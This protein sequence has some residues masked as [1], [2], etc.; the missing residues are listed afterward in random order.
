[1][2]TKYN[3]R[4][5]GIKIPHLKIL[6]RNENIHEIFTS[7]PIIAYSKDKSIG[8]VII[9]SRLPQDYTAKVDP[10]RGRP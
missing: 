5:K 1:M 10:G 8:D 9:R 2:V 7:E 3:P 6:E 4:I